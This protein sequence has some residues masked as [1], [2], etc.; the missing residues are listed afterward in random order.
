M[1]RLEKS[2]YYRWIK[3]F[4]IAFVA[5][6]GLFIFYVLIVSANLLNLFGPTP[7]LKSLEKP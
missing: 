3:W 7:D 1:I 4:W 6:W 2:T 5:G